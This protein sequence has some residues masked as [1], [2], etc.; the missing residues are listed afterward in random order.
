MQELL[1]E[2]VTESELIAVVVSILSTLDRATS[3]IQYSKIYS[4]LQILGNYI[5]SS[6]IRIGLATSNKKAADLLGCFYEETTAI[7][8]I[9][10][11][12]PLFKQ[13]VKERENY[14]L[15][16]EYAKILEIGANLA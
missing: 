16:Q 5:K 2:D 15:P 7:N 9:Q 1:N 13:L 3:D 14:N 6:G 12:L 11:S 8:I 4:N 10:R